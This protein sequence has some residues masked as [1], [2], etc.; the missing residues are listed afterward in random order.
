MKSRFILG[1]ILVALTSGCSTSYKPELYFNPSEPIRIAVLPFAQVDNTG[2]IIDED[3]NLLIDNVALVSSKL[4][5]RPAQLMQDLVQSELAQASLDLVPPP[6]VDA[7]LHHSPYE[8]VGSKPLRLD[9]A[10]LMKAD[11]KTLCSSILSCDAVLYG[12][13]TRW[14]RS[15]YGIESVATVGLDLKLVSA[16]TG[17]LLFKTSARDSDSRGLSKGPTGFSNLVIEPLQGLDNEIITDL[18][19]TMVSKAIAP[20]TGRDRPEFLSAPAPIIIAAS[21]SARS[22]TL[23][24]KG[25]LIVVVY[26]SP[27]MAGSFDIG[28]A[29]QGVPLVERSKGHYIGEFIPLASDSFSQATVSTSLRDQVGRVTTHQL[30]RKPVSLR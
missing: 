6:I 29:I 3:P 21:H 13:V 8:V 2:A 26:G 5:Q 11:P 14:D 30:T 23:P 28:Q 16:K 9:V 24:A 25:R 10:R 7:L 17:K 15:Y 4:N 27:G 20:L 19:R 22:G 1:I 12:T 18:A